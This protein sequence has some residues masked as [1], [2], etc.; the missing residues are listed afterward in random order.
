LV[1]IKHSLR[2]DQ[3]E[4]LDLRMV[5][6]LSFINSEHGLW[7]EL[8]QGGCSI[9]M[10]KPYWFGGQT[11]AKMCKQN[12]PMVEVLCGKVTVD[13]TMIWDTYSNDHG[14]L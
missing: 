11:F 10:Y 2:S 12:K 9:Y 13:L 4:A 5:A 6:I 7:F 8:G 3:L 14:L 1:K